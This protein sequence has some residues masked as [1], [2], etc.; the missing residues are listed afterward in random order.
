MNEN[1]IS[2]D[3][4]NIK[5]KYMTDEQKKRAL[6]IYRNCNDKIESK[7]VA[8]NIKK[9]EN[10]EVTESELQEEKRVC[11][12][13]NKK[14][15]IS[16]LNEIRGFGLAHM[17]CY[18]NAPVC[19]IC[20]Q[21]KLILNEDSDKN[22]ICDYRCDNLCTNCWTNEANVKGGLC[23]DCEWNKYYSNKAACR[24]CVGNVVDGSLAG[25]KCPECG[26]IFELIN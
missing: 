21:T 9:Q 18:N 4:N 22:G 25:T 7:K 26:E 8:E 19:S 1:I 5:N 17:S 20:H 10:I 12:I 6:E 14:D 11:F 2:E 24:G 13:C 15:Y 3:G 16:N 23:N